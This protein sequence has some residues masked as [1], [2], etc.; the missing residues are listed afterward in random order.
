M[1][2]EDICNPWV[3]KY[4]QSVQSA[5]GRNKMHLILMVSFLRKEVTR[6]ENGV[7]MPQSTTVRKLKNET[8]SYTQYKIQLGRLWVD[9]LK[10]RLI[11]SWMNE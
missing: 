11:N 8:I 7:Q 4:S 1:D 3:K 5:Y 6:H 2:T 10:G 9:F